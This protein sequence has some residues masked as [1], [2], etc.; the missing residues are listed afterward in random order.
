MG[1]IQRKSRRSLVSLGPRTM[2]LWDHNGTEYSHRQSAGETAHKL[3]GFIAES[4]MS[5]TPLTASGV[6][7]VLPIQTML[8][9]QRGPG[10]SEGPFKPVC[11][12]V[13]D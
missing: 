2:T 12:S 9:N 10:N 8:S 5:G 7:T 3:A 6:V 13:D 1:E 4:A 11:V